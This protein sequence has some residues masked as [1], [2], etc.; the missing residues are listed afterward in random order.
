MATAKRAGGLYW[1]DG[2]PVDFEGKEVPNAP[3]REPNTVV[4]R[5]AIER[6]ADERSA[7]RMG[8]AIAKALAPLIPA[9]SITSVEDPKDPKD[10]KETKNKGDK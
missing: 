10:P 4:D 5:V 7:D 3:A 1:V 2:K 9:P 8:E 6:T